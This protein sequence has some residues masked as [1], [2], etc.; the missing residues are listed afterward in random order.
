MDMQIGIFK[1]AEAN[2]VELIG[3]GLIII[4]FSIVAYYSLFSKES[5]ENPEVITENVGLPTTPE[6]NN[7][8]SS[9]AISL[10]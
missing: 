3:Y 7:P 4:G 6:G 5:D 2:Y 10:K 9:T 8:N 1:F